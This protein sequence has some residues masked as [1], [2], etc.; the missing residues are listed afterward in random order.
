MILFILKLIMS[1]FRNNRIYVNFSIRPVI[2]TKGSIRN[3]IVEGLDITHQKTAEEKVNKL[4][5]EKEMLLREVHHRIKNNMATVE[6]LFKIKS[7][8]SDDEK[9]KSAFQEA[10]SRLSSM[11]I[12]YDKL[13]LSSDLKSISLQ[14]YLPGLAREVVTV[15]PLGSEVDLQLEIDN[16]TIP[17]DVSFPLCIMIN[18]LITNSMKYAFDK[19]IK[20]KIIVLKAKINKSQVTINLSDNGLGLPEDFDFESSQGFGVKLCKNLA[21]QIKGEISYS[22]ENGTSWTI[23]FNI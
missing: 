8:M 3:L 11:R 19:S 10:I 5:K 7:M 17:A 23:T 4:L 21:K 18:E 6:S 1:V 13:Y 12:L 9:I 20:Q 22:I 14:E 15:F 16:I 2:D